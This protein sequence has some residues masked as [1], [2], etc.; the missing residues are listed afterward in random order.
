M[1]EAV[2]Y[3]VIIKVYLKSYFKAT[4]E[5]DLKKKLGYNLTFGLYSQITLR[6]NVLDHHF[7]L[8]EV[9]MQVQNGHGAS[10]G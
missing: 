1:A 4:Y 6:S 5:L 3:K 8:P 7:Y 10:A 9:D 2:D